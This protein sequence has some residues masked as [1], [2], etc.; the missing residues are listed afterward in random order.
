[1][2]EEFRTSYFDFTAKHFHEAVLGAKIADR[3]PFQRLLLLDEKRSA[4]RGLTSNGQAA[5]RTGASGS[6]VLCRGCGCSGSTDAWLPEGPALARQAGIGSSSEAAN[7][8][9]AEVYR[10]SHNARFAVASSEEGSAFVP[11][12]G[13]LDDILCVIIC[14][15][16]ERAVSNGNPPCAMTPHRRHFVQAKVRVHEYCDGSLA[17]FLRP[18]PDRGLRARRGSRKRTNILNEGRLP[19]SAEE[20]PRSAARRRDAVCRRGESQRLQGHDNRPTRDGRRR[21]RRYRNANPYG[22]PRWPSCDFVDTGLGGLAFC[23]FGGD[24]G[25][26]LTADDWSTFHG[27][28]QVALGSIACWMANLVDKFGS[29]GSNAALHRCIVPAIS[30][31]AHRLD[32]PRRAQKLAIIAAP[33]SE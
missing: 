10:A 13:D 32:H 31:P 24:V 9:L 2:A 21:A 20:R 33:R 25:R 18:A 23:L 5:R 15:E 22:G 29:H 3:R 19:H 28:E 30:L 6:G 1:M 7:R 12:A 14:L 17:H 8:W 11:F 27:G 26:N 16:E 4:S